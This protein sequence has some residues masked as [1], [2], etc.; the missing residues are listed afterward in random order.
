MDVAKFVSSSF[1]VIDLIHS[2]EVIKNIYLGAAAGR[3]LL[4]SIATIEVK[5]QVDQNIYLR[6]QQAN[7]FGVCLIDVSV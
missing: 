7:G 4:L 6:P 5:E 1:K 2:R 3:K